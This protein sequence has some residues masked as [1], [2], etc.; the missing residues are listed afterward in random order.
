VSRRAIIRTTINLP[1]NL[2]RGIIMSSKI[3][4]IWKEEN[5]EDSDLVKSFVHAVSKGIELTISDEDIKIEVAQSDRLIDFSILVMIEK[6]L[7]E[8]KGEATLKKWNTL[9][10]AHEGVDNSKIFLDPDN[11]VKLEMFYDEK[12]KDLS[13][14]SY[15]HFYKPTE[16]SESK[17]IKLEVEGKALGEALSKG[18]IF[19]KE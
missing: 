12:E 5:S 13:I 7:D 15:L 19:L 11:Q 4:F 17:R 10:P 9:E 6:R 3:T 8:L 18:M 2:S 14:F 1:E 16:D